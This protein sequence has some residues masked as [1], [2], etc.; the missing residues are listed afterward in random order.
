M[1]EVGKIGGERLSE[2]GLDQAKVRIVGEVGEIGATP[3]KKVIQGDDF[4]A[5]LQEPIN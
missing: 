4:I 1:G 2:I 5:C 3:R